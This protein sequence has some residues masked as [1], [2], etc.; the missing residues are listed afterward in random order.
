MSTWT[1]K[2][3]IVRQRGPRPDQDDFELSE[4]G[5]PQI[6]MFTY[7]DIPAA[8]GQVSRRESPGFV[9]CQNNAIAGGLAYVLMLDD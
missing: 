6:E 7:V 2:S 1:R 5:K 8:A 4:D 9:R 3:P